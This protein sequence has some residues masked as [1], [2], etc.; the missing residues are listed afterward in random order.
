MESLKRDAAGRWRGNMRTGTCAAALLL[1]IGE[2]G[3]SAQS[4]VTVQ[5]LIKDGYT[6][7]GVIPSSAGPGLFL[8]KGDDLVVCFVAETPSSPTVATRYC[9]PVR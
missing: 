5:S 8:Q 4:A 9:K 3:A 6:V 2:V 7:V 1:T